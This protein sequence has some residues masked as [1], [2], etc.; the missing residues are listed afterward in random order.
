M[1]G[2]QTEVA[3]ALAGAACKEEESGIRL[4]GILGLTMAARARVLAALAGAWGEEESGMAWLDIL[5]RRM[6]AVVG[7]AASTGA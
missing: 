4:L 6:A 3:S 1:V 7:V 5:D 2:V